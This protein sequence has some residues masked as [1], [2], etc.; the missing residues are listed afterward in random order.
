MVYNGSVSGRER[1]KQVKLFNDDNSGKN[2]I[3]AQSASAK[4][5][6]SFHDTTGKIQRV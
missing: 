4:E 3:L 1:I 6:V 2:L 5:G